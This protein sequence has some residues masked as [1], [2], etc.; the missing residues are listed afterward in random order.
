MEGNDV[1]KCILLVLPGYFFLFLF[2]SCQPALAGLSW[3]PPTEN[4]R[5]ATDLSI[6]PDGVIYIAESM[7]GRIEVFDRN[8]RY[9]TA[10]P[11]DYPSAIAVDSAGRLYVGRGKYSTMMPPY[12]I[13][14]EV[15]IYESRGRE[16]VYVASLGKGAGEFVNPTD[17]YADR[18]GNI[19][20]VDS[21]AHN[22]KVYGSEGNRI[23]TI[24]QYGKGDG[25][26]NHPLAVTVDELSG[27][28]YITDKQL[29]PDSTLGDVSGARVQVF[30]AE[31][32]YIRGFGRY[33][34]G[35]LI[36]PSDI[37]VHDG[38]VY[39]A[40]SYQN[41]VLV[42]D[43][44]SGAMADVRQ[45]PDGMLRVPV[46]LA[47]SG[48]GL[49]YIVAAHTGRLYRAGAGD[50]VNMTIEPGSLAFEATAG[51][52]VPPTQTVTVGNTG[53]DLLGWAAETDRPWIFID[54]YGGEVGPGMTN[55]VHVGVDRSALSEG[56]HT[57][58]VVFRSAG[59]TAEVVPLTFIVKPQT[60]LTVNPQEL[61]FEMIDGIVPPAQAIRVEIG[62]GTLQTRWSAVTDNNWLTVN[63]V[64]AGTETREAMVGIGGGA[65]VPGEYHGMVRVES[66][67]AIG[68]PA[69]VS[70]TLLVK[71][72]GSITVLTNRDDATYTIRGD[73]GTYEGSGRTWNVQGV[74]AGTYLI[75]FHAVAGYR[76]PAGESKTL[77]RGGRI[78][79]AGEYRSI[80]QRLVT[81]KRD[82]ASGMVRILDAWG[83]VLHA[84]AGFGNLE[85]DQDI[86]LGD[87]DGDGE[88]EIVVSMMKGGSG[89]S[90]FSGAGR[91]LAGG[92]A[93]SGESG[94][95]VE[96]GDVDGDGIAEI[97]ALGR[98][99]SMLKIFRYADGTLSDTGLSLKL[100]GVKMLAC[101]DVDGDGTEEVITATPGE[102]TAIQI[103][104]TTHDGYGWA[105]Q[106]AGKIRIPIWAA[107][108]GTMNAGRGEAVRLLVID[109]SGRTY[110]LDRD[111]N[112]RKMVLPV[113]GACDIDSGDVDGDG[114]PEMIVGTNSGGMKIFGADG[115][116][117]ADLRVNNVKSC[118]RLGIGDVGG[119]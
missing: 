40:D 20:V 105:V 59:G 93:F 102:R 74:A 82:G 50:F 29:V 37:A 15:K 7:A 69:E 32:G 83:S 101:G 65:L 9:R 55:T 44:V 67:G 70:V 2:L 10:F 68:S 112:A 8:G 99:G 31:G 62:G 114:V 18:A 119:Y 33:L 61:Q 109:K 63:P 106:S 54:T 4:V 47:I 21:D 71:D 86:A 92:A 23:R 26:L 98:D 52:A 19:Y 38:L 104:R 46:S 72:T 100:D 34:P 39:I 85:G 88:N 76:P 24:G 14:G 48:D 57:G 96:T 91:E 41:A 111:G 64:E 35:E 94:V 6:A 17:I 75:E 49:L 5:C 1:R 13:P 30:S 53:N 108:I 113:Q 16:L 90:I 73:H 79:F 3:L 107:A 25:Y 66:E 45:A 22:V 95:S 78:E 87:L 36:S 58:S 81:S 110:V 60:V 115:K 43:A 84:F 42:Y 118:V 89:V 116:A 103:W 51:G 12:N 11:A 27:D 80:Q 28:I 56:T 77:D 97:L 117:R